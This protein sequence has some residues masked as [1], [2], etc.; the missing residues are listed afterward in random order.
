LLACGSGST[1]IRIGLA[2]PFTDS[3]GA[4][5]QRAA[6]LAVA[7]INAR[8][9]VRGRP[10]ALVIRNDFGDPDSAVGAATAL[11]KAGVV[12][13]VGHVYSGTTL[14][15]APIYNDPAH[16]VVAIS[17]SSSAPAVTDAGPW[18]FRVCPSDLQ[19]GAALARFTRDRL[20][21]SRGTVFYL[22]DDYG[23]GIRSVFAAEFV[24]RGGMI[25]DLAPYLGATPDVSPYLDRV[26]RQ[27]TSRF[28]FVAGNR[29]E[30]ETV[31]RGVRARGLTL[32]VLGGDGLE[33]IEDAGDL[34]EGTYLSNA[35]LPTATTLKN[36]A[37]VA[38]YQRAYPG[39]APP[40]QPAAATYDILYLLREVIARTGTDRRRVRDGVAQV[41]TSGP[42]FEGLLGPIAF[43]ANGDVPTTRVLIGQ[44]HAGRIELVESE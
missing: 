1:P 13:V 23:R 32:P 25:D 2:G 14:A 21:L 42:P 20:G 29:S 15:A 24:R 8:G 40:N 22:N 28:L 34:S 43:D 44:V 31:L 36:R 4:P 11:E 41:G 39:A 12:A 26:A 5:M 7:E 18:I 6:Q 16:P 10:L 19:Q 30:A 37:F 33:G 38:A 3:V 17:P 35:Y 9:G 27:K